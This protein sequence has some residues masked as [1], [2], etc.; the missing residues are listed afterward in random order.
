V[1]IHNIP[2]NIPLQLTNFI[3][4]EQEVAEITQLLARTRLVSLVGA[5]GIGKSRL[6]LRVA[7]SVAETFPDGI[8]FIELAS[9]LDATLLYQYLA[10]TIGIQEEIGVPLATTLCAFLAA[11]KVLLILDNCEHLIDAC[12]VCV[13]TLLQA[14]ATLSILATSREVL[15]IGAETVFRVPSLSVPPLDETLLPTTVQQFEAVTLFVERAR[16]VQ[17]HFAL[18]DATTEA[19]VQVCQQLDGIPLALELAVGRLSVMPI[20]Q[21]A[22]RLKEQLSTFLQLLSRGTRTAPSR[23]QTLRATIDWSYNLLSPLEQRLLQRLAIFVGGWT[24][25]AAEA[26]CSDQEIAKD[27][28]LDLLG[29]LVNKSLI[30]VGE[31]PLLADTGNV[32]SFHARYRFLE[33]VRQYAHEKLQEAGEEQELQKRHF[34]YFLTLAQQA[35]N[36]IRGR[37]Q[38]PWLHRLDRERD[39]LRVALTYALQTPS[40]L[41]LA[42]ALAWYWI[43][44]NDFSEGSL[45]LQEMLARSKDEATSRATALYR[46]GVLAWCRSDFQRLAEYSEQSLALFGALNDKRGI[47]WSLSNLTE[48]TRWRGDYQRAL[49]LGEEAV[50]TLQETED[51]WTLAYTYIPLMVTLRQQGKTAEALL[52]GQKSVALFRSTGDNWGLATILSLL[53]VTLSNA[54]DT[55]QAIPYLQE[56]MNLFETFGDKN[57]KASV[58]NV[59]GMNFL[60]QGNDEKARPIIEACKTLFK[61]RG[62]LRFVAQVLLNE[63]QTVLQRSDYERARHCFEECLVLS[64]KNEDTR[65]TGIALYF[66]GVIAMQQRKLHDSASLLQESL[67]MLSQDGNKAL[68]IDCIG[69]LTLLMGQ[70]I[71]HVEQAQQIA[72]W[73]GFVQQERETTGVPLSSLL[74]PLHAETVAKIHEFLEE[75][76]FEI[77]TQQGQALTIEHVVEDMRS[78]RTA[79]L[80]ANVASPVALT[81]PQGGLHSSSSATLLAALTNR[82][83][84]VLHLIAVGQS[85][86]QVAETLSISSGTVK[87]HLN[88]IYSK[89]G[90][91]SRTA[92]IHYARQQHLL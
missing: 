90:V 6:A 13:E 3:G 52:L 61:D 66:L 58:L 65:R 39:N 19:V 16:S 14:C 78:N 28:V 23:Q 37:K 44:R 81:A 85:N 20:E 12:A 33:T 43:I 40:G 67:D 64:R 31:E 38:L 5:G 88:S 22:T 62:N 36:H 47:G 80:F 75:A 18:T 9:L 68:L 17:Q 86:A 60:R 11:K 70:A 51:T 91:R 29:Q 8:W 10:S 83:L 84:E 26:I 76:L 45:W 32:A 41:Q 54:G 71:A 57:G 87:T 50:A 92:A 74:G 82:E 69:V 1:K 49:L 63:G 59:L 53:G 56:S 4:R 55:K 24:L 79:R 27:N 7:E 35:D 25:E 42:S 21:L 48:L 34:A 30:A 73:L 77:A 72:Q 46:A 2:N 15:N 89:F